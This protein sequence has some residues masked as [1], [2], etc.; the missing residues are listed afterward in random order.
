MAPPPISL[1]LLFVHSFSFGPGANV[2]AAV[3][4][5]LRRHTVDGLVQL[6]A[7]VV[8]NLSRDLFV[9]LFVTILPIRKGNQC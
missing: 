4:L 1:S 9:C 7:L 6:G 8:Q 5:E 2:V 3:R